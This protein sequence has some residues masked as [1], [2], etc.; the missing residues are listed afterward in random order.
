MEFWQIIGL[1][2]ITNLLI[3]MLGFRWGYTEG[4]L[5]IIDAILELAA[6]EEEG[7]DV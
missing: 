1:I 2:G 3:A 4:K 6:E 7:R 5:E